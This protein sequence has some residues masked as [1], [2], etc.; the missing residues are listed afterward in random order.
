MKLETGA[1]VAINGSPVVV[2]SSTG[3]NHL[4][5]LKPSDPVNA[6]VIGEGVC[7][8]L[9]L[10]TGEE[11]E[12]VEH[13]ALTLVSWMALRELPSLI[14]KYGKPATVTFL[15]T[16]A[17]FL[18]DAKEALVCRENELCEENE[19]ICLILNGDGQLEIDDAWIQLSNTDWGAYRPAIPLLLQLAER[20]R[21]E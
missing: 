15:E 19:G 17:R 7:G 20:L 3:G 10:G 8:S 1:T 9:E 12:F 13:T 14:A 21:S 2:I 11:I 18:R 16:L 6:P 5:F 4:Y